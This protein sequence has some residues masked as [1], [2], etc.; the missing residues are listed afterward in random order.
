VIVFAYT[1]HINFLLYISRGHHDAN[2]NIA[3]LDGHK[4]LVANEKF[5][6]AGGRRSA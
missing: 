4:E 1:V 5:Q 3:I 6:Q 2:F